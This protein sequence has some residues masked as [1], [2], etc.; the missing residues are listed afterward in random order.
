MGNFVAYMV[1]G[2]Q[3]NSFI[4]PVPSA[5]LPFSIS[6]AVMAMNAHRPIIEYLQRHR[7]VLLMG[8]VKKNS[9]LLVDFTNQRRES[10]LEVTEALLNACPLRLARSL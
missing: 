4:H 6:G 9:I 3:F 8:I 5:G 10:G 7:I 2:T 1:L